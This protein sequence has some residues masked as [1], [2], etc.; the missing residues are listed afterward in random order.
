MDLQLV[1]DTNI[2]TLLNE[3]K[4]TWQLGSRKR[5]I[6]YF[7]FCNIIVTYTYLINYAQTY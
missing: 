6:S 7:P 3:I 4:L 5:K 2:V 1:H